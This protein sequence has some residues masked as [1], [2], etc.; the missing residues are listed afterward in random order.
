MR[1]R[2]THKVGDGHFPQIPFPLLVDV[3]DLLL[4]YVVNEVIHMIPALHHHYIVITSPQ[5]SHSH[6]KTDTH[7]L[8]LLLS[9][10]YTP[11]H[12]QKHTHTLHY[13]P[14]TYSLTHYPSLQAASLSPSHTHSVTHTLPLSPSSLLISLT[15][16]LRHSHT[17]PLS[18]QPPQASISPSHTHSVTHTLPLSLSSHPLASPADSPEEVNGEE[19]VTDV[20]G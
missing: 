4:G 5:S 1:E 10:T 12:S 3:R 11:S 6:R 15:H 2:Y 14:T 19:V 7:F 8:F 17:T 9:H 20:A 13:L 18:K 16:S